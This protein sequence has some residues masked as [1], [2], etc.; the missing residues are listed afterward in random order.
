LGAVPGGG[1]HCWG[2]GGGH[3]FDFIDVGVVGFDG[4]DSLAMR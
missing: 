4:F 2:E 1:F 3:F